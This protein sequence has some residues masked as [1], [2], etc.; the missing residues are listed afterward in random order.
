[1]RIVGSSSRNALLKRGEP[2]EQVLAVL[3][4]TA[5]AMVALLGVAVRS[6]VDIAIGLSLLVLSVIEIVRWQRGQAAMGISSSR[7]ARRGDHAVPTTAWF[8]IGGITAAF[9]FGLIWGWAQTEQVASASPS[10]APLLSA[11]VYLAFGG[12]TALILSRMHD[13]REREL[14]GMPRRLKMPPP[15]PL[16]AAATAA[17]SA[18]PVH[19]LK[20]PTATFYHLQREHGVELDAF[21]S[22]HTIESTH[23]DLHDSNPASPDSAG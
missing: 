12:L 20:G 7:R 9:V 6:L 4:S 22:D 19:D 13:R 2:Y 10:V 16:S 15:P 1:M 18:S 8:G 11:V 21:S 17:H 23:V 14:A 3:G 5:W